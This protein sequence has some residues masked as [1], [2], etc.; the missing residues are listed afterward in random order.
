MST[1]VNRIN[2]NQDANLGN[3]DKTLITSPWTIIMIKY[4]IV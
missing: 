3:A 2:L 4:E 1:T